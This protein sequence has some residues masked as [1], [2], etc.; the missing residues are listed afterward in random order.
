MRGLIDAL[1]RNHSTGFTNRLIRTP[2]FAFDVESRS[3]RPL[4]EF[5]FETDPSSLQPSPRSP[6]DSSARRLQPSSA[7]A[8]PKARDERASELCR[9]RSYEH[10][11]SFAVG[12]P[13]SADTH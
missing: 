7:D 13:D 6:L 9:L 10:P 5:V 12:S 11:A 1:R 2:A 8:R 3:V 4:R